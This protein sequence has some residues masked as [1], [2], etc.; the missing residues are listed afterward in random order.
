MDPS[1]TPAPLN[2]LPLSLDGAHA[3]A[4]LRAHLA[5]AL[6][7]AGLGTF[8]LDPG[9]FEGEWDPRAAEVLGASTW[10][11][12]LLD[13][14]APEEEAPLRRAFGALL[15]PRAA[16]TVHLDFKV[17]GASAR[18][19][20]CS[21]AGALAP[22]EGG[23]LT[24]VGTLQ[25]V[26]EA[27]LSREQRQRLEAELREANQRLARSQAL[28]DAMIEHAPVG[29]GLVDRELRFQRVNER[30]AA[31]NGLAAAEHAGRTPRELLPDL[32]LDAW[33]A[34]WRRVL[35]TGEPATGLELSGRTPASDE[36][37]YWKE[38]LYRVRAGE[39][40]LGVG[41]LVEDV[42]DTKRREEMQRLL[43]GVVG[44]DLRNPLST[45]LNGLHVLRAEP[46]LSERGRRTLDRM[47]N[48]AAGM[49][50]LVSDLL[51]YTRIRAGQ[52]IP[53]SRLPARL[54]DV[55]VP[56]VE[57]A[58]LAHP[59]RSIVCS[60][61]GDDAGRWD[62]DR[63]GQ[64]VSNL[65]TNALKHGARGEPI[66]VRWRGEERAVVL[67]VA[68]GGPPIPP[69]LL[70]RLFEPM[71]QGEARRDGVGLGLFITREVVR[72]HGGRVVARSSPE[73][74]TVFEVE[75]PRG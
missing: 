63:L 60:G 57:D 2:D 31:I 12:R 66:E 43:V 53:V 7:A 6:E 44:H 29:I 22:R 10:R 35:E 17:A 50:R 59:D 30:L 64:V 9:S 51:D 34:A 72:A 11:G 3:L 52:G 5:A 68:N 4:R 28:L 1:P 38:A 74:G 70:A 27:R 8:S 73:L 40:T 32:P 54:R 47:R 23:G 46:A 69:E 45:F 41:V 13:H 49:D 67:E 55:V 24:V 56:L 19:R 36:L 33:E 65:L 16:G 25:D 42:T 75:L 21:L 20:W 39:E 14:A 18:P 61:Q 48:A 62:P 71:T 58:R 15:G 37:R 26:T